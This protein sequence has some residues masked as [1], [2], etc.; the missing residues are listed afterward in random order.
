MKK[1]LVAEDT[2]S[3]FLLLNILLRKQYQVSHALNGQ[4][5]IDMYNSEQPDIILMDIKMPEMDG[6]EATR[7][8]RAAGCTIPIVALTA[9]AYDSDREK[10][11]DAGCDDYMSK[12][13]SAPALREMMVRL[14]GE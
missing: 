12:P 14:L 11:F 1:V 10:A 2:E 8:L 13:I 6:L 5:A 9:N 3:N 7:Q 4:Q